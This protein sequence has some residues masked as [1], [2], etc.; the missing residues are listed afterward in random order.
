MSSAKLA[1]LQEDVNRELADIPDE[2]QTMQ[3]Q[4]IRGLLHAQRAADQGE[5]TRTAPASMSDSNGRPSAS[6]LRP[7]V[8]EGARPPVRATPPVFWEDSNPELAAMGHEPL[9]FLSQRSGASAGAASSPVG[10]SSVTST[11]HTLRSAPQVE[12]SSLN[13]IN[14]T[15][16]RAPTTTLTQAR[17]V[18]DLY[19]SDS[20]ANRNP[21][22]A[23]TLSKPQ[24]PE[25]LPV[26][27]SRAREE[28]FEQLAE[29]LQSEI[30]GIKASTLRSA[31]AWGS[32]FEQMDEAEGRTGEP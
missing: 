17:S 2:V 20:G 1:R 27:E 30:P 19:T 12:S 21:P 10:T 28:H 32:V 7:I 4:L 24:R 29:R 3:L 9:E 15:V 23:A 8:F 31:A 25:I 16:V 26:E 5:A 6:A 22:L 13:P 11:D 18:R 14:T